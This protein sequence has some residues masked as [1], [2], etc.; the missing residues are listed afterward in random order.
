MASWMVYHTPDV[1][2]M[3]KAKHEQ[4]GVEEEER[5]GVVAPTSSPAEV[6]AVSADELRLID[7]CLLFMRGDSI[8]RVYGAGTY[9]RVER[10]QL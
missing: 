2:R 5:T 3:L 9:W 4:A 6:D 8:I 7:G 10:L 1:V